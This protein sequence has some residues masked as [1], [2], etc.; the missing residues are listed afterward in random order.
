M[1][2]QIEVVPHC[3]RCGRWNVVVKGYAVRRLL[4]ASEVFEELTKVSAMLD[5]LG[6]R[7]EAMARPTPSAET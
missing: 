6:L 4:C 2:V 1:M 5:A 3:E 7:S